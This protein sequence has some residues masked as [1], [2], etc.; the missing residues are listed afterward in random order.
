G[1]WAVCL[2]AGCVVGAPRVP[3]A[4]RGPAT[5][6]IAG[7][8]FVAEP[9]WAGVGPIVGMDGL[10]PGFLAVSLLALLVG[11]GFGIEPAP[12]LRGR[13]G[14]GALAGLAFGLAFL[15]KTTV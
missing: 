14:W 13:I 7:L 2:V 5:G 9:F 8:L 12:G 3:P 1:C 11:A 10:L 6:L 15:S 4:W